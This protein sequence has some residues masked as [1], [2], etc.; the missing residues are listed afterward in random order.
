MLKKY[1]LPLIILP[2][3]IYIFG[4]ITL[5]STSPSLVNNHLIFFAV[6]VVFY[7][8]FA[9]IEYNI[10]KHVWKYLYVAGAVLLLVTIA[11]AEFRSGSARWLS[12]GS[13]NFQTSEFAKLTLILSVSAYVAANKDAVS[14][15][16]TILFTALLTCLYVVLIFM[17]PD[18]GTSLVLMALSGGIIFYA[19]LNKLYIL[20][21]ILLVGVFSSP[22]WRMLKDYQQE[23]IIVFLNPQLDV[24]GSGYNVIQSVIAVGSGGFQGK[25]FGQGTQANLKFLPAYWTD[26]IFASFAEEW[27]FVGV[28]LFVSVF[29][30]FMVWILKI[31]HEV[32]DVFGKLICVGVFSVFFT[33]FTVNVGMNLGIMPVTG[34]TLPLVSYGGSSMLFSM[35]MIGIVHNVWQKNNEKI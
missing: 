23:R 18:L 20:G 22:I 35:I 9:S 25:G 21:A 12:L 31:S 13:L 14:S 4:F 10:Y 5:L 3:I 6:G 28:F 1:N 27:G 24:L 19:G 34:V 30:F 32:K 7:Y 8:I 33:Q 29:T 26:F 2:F 17:Q 15:F 11:F 16:K